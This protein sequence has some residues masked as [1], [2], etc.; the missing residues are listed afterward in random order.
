MR[1]IGLA[2]AVPDPQHVRRGAAERAG[3]RRILAC[4]R[5]LVAEQQRL[6]TGVEL[7]AL[8]LWKTLEIEAAGL[9]EAER[10]ADA[11]GELLIMVRLGRVLD[12]AERPLPDAGEIGVAARHERAQQLERRSEPAI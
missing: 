9:H 1:V 8:E 11:V 6:V 7:G 12:E 3:V 2:G 10:L 4:H 5:L